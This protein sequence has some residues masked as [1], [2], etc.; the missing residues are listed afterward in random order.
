MPQLKQVIVLR[1]DLGISKGKQISQACH[2]SLKSYKKVGS[3]MQKDWED[4]GSRKVVVESSGNDLEE[5]LER[6]KG[7]QIPAALVK[8]A[9]RTEV[10]PGTVTA[11]GVGPADEEKIDKVT[12]D[13]KLV[14]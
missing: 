2:A 1:E 9:G 7:L 10:K 8:D 12:G 3:Q 13:L 11:L 5:R 14:K 4:Q 6:A